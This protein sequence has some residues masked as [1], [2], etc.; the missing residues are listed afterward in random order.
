MKEPE[1]VTGW[2]LWVSDGTADG[3]IPLEFISR[4]NIEAVDVETMPLSDN[5][6]LFEGESE[7]IG[8]ELLKA[9]R[10][11]VTT[12]TQASPPPGSPTSEDEDNTTSGA[13]NLAPFNLNSV[14]WAIVTLI[15]YVGC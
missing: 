4:S 12:P 5:I 7:E 3:T 14:S 13:S 10:R 6:I 8:R 2:Q 9:T 11:L 1:N 15:L